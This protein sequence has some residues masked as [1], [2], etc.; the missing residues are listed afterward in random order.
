VSATRLREARGWSEE[1]WAA[2]ADRLR[3]RGWID[4]ADG[5][6]QA[7]TAVRE[8]VEQRTDERA[9]PP[10]SH[11]GE[12]GCDRLTASLQPVLAALAAADL[13]PYPNPM[14]LPPPP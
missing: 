4:G 9:L 10:W 13:I 6:T 8:R 12:A 11:L 1:E 2:A 5:L 14:G 3:D 7:G